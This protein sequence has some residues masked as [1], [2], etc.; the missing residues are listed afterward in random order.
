V[1]IVLLVTYQYFRSKKKQENE[2]K[3]KEA[4]ENMNEHKDVPDRPES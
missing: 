4:N 3:A 2:M 1:I